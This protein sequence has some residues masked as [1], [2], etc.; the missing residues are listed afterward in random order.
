MATDNQPPVETADSLVS[1]VIS[2]WRTG[3]VPN[4]QSVLDE[5]PELRNHHSLVLDLAYE[6]YC[7]RR[8]AGEPVAMSTFCDRFPT[9]CKWAFG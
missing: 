1:Q 2:S 3:S 5:H 8:Q 7:L 9:V 4:A 6:E